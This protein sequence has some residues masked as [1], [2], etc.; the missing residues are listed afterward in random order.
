MSV[1]SYQSPPPSNWRLPRILTRKDGRFRLRRWWCNFL[2][3]PEV[4]SSHYQH[5]G[6]GLV[7]G[8][9]LYARCLFYQSFCPN[10]K[11]HCNNTSR[12]YQYIPKVT[13]PHHWW[14]PLS[15][16]LAPG[17][18]SPSPAICKEESRN[19]NPNPHTYR[20][21]HTK[22][23]P[24]MVELTFR[25]Y[26]R[27]GATHIPKSIAAFWDDWDWVTTIWMHICCISSPKKDTKQ[28]LETYVV[29]KI[30]V[31]HAWKFKWAVICPVPCYHHE[32]LA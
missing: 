21:T 6:D 27:G 32:N 8:Q 20:N 16:L 26:T 25:L 19:P 5:C 24:R 22:K 10:T 31:L 11:Y 13:Q 14:H 12:W 29:K 2:S 23:S 28:K 9:K 18:P 30:P 1:S 15:L 3:A 4:T 7:F 17:K